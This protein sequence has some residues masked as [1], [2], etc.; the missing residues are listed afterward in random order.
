MAKPNGR[1]V[2]TVLI[3]GLSSISNPKNIIN[4]L[5]I[6]ALSFLFS[7]NAGLQK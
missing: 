2:P 5:I 3:N 1:I 4:I 6:F 7:L